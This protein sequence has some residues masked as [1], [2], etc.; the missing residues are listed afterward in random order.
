M[1]ECHRRFASCA[2]IATAARS[3]AVSRR[4]TAGPHTR[5]SF[6]IRCASSQLMLHCTIRVSNL[7][8]VDGNDISDHSTPDASAPSLPPNRMCSARCGACPGASPTLAYLMFHL[9]WTPK[10]TR[11]AHSCVAEI[12]DRTGKLQIFSLTLCQ[13]IYRCMG[14]VVPSRISSGGQKTALAS[15]AALLKMQSSPCPIHAARQQ[16]DSIGGRRGRNKRPNH[17]AVRSSSDLCMAG[18]GGRRLAFGAAIATAARPGAVSRWVAAGPHNLLFS[19]S[20]SL[21]L[22]RSVSFSSVDAHVLEEGGI[23]SA[24]NR[25]LATSTATMQ[26]YN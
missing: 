8:H 1:G 26:I 4:V 3:G 5:F 10:W 12:R 19:F 17:S 15:I 23:A 24:R 7:D 18:G 13:L 22:C 20:F 14:E 6:F 25:T 9:S 16:E 2:T 21:S 11:R